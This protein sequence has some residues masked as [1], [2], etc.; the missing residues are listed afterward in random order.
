MSDLIRYSHTARCDWRGCGVLGSAGEWDGWP[1]YDD[2]VEVLEDLDDGGEWYHDP[3]TGKD[4]C[5]K[6]W[7]WEDDEPVPGPGSEEGA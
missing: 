6:H 1:S 3:A 5:G 4:F 2:A 7:H